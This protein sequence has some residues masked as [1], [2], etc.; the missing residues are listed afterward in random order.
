M[1][2]CPSYSAVPGKRPECWDKKV[3]IL[4]MVDFMVVPKQ[5]DLSPEFY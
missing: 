3:K 5:P 2:R 4:T 1:P